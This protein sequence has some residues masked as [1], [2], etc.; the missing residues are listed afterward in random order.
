MTRPLTVPIVAMC[1]VRR[2]PII[3]NNILTL[4]LIIFCIE[5][6][7][8]TYSLINSP[9]LLC[10]HECVCGISWAGWYNIQYSLHACTFLWIA[11]LWHL[12]GFYD[13]L[14][15]IR[16]SHTGTPG[17]VPSFSY[18]GEKIH[19]EKYDWFFAPDVMYLLIIK[20]QLWWYAQL[21]WQ[22]HLFCNGLSI[23]IFTLMLWAFLQ[24]TLTWDHFFIW[25]H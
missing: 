5:G 16:T 11:W 12:W 2:L 25:I 8:H 10:L 9:T 21:C 17:T 14:S 24:P 20:S 4:K 3:Y 15:P 7:H 22:S 19:L 6:Y 23:V 13:L 18:K 1:C